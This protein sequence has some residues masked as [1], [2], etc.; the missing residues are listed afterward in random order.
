MG[1]YMCGFEWAWAITQRRQQ[2]HQWVRVGFGARL[3][4]RAI[5]YLWAVPA[6][7]LTRGGAQQRTSVGRRYDVHGAGTPWCLAVHC[8]DGTCAVAVLQLIA[9]RTC[10][11]ALQCGGE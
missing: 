7:G 1:A 2:Q 10:A 5:S 11:R 9:V 8:D 6:T 4:E 3:S